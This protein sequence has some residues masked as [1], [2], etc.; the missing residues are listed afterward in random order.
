MLAQ[1]Y[2]PEDQIN[3]IYSRIYD[4]F[5]QNSMFLDYQEN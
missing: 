2:G 3:L 5:D 4:A 1:S